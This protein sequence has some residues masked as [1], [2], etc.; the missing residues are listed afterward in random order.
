[1][2]IE[3]IQQAITIQ[4]LIFKTDSSFSIFLLDNKKLENILHSSMTLT[5][6]DLNDVIKRLVT[7]KSSDL[8]SRLATEKHSSFT[9]GFLVVKD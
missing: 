5:L 3:I 8:R 4:N 9:R 2:D 1:L 6:D 7:V